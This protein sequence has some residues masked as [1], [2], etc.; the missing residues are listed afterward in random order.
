MTFETKYSRMD[1]EKFAEN[2]F[3]KICEVSKNLKCP[4]RANPTKADKLFDHFVWFALKKLRL[5]K[6]SSKMK[7]VRS[8]VASICNEYRVL[9]I[10]F[11]RFYL[12]Q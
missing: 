5:L 6:T 7:C 9:F 1:Q 8:K 12:F 10:W 2:S 3:E 11:Q 4:L